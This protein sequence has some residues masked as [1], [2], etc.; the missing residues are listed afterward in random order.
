MPPSDLA[1]S[2]LNYGS[3]SA[4]CRAT[5]RSHCAAINLELHTMCSGPEFIQLRIVFLEASGGQV[6]HSTSKSINGLFTLA[7]AFLE[8][9]KFQMTCY[10]VNNPPLPVSWQTVRPFTNS[11]AV[12]WLLKAL[13]GLD[14]Y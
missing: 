9:L 8:L 12:G 3:A 5:V 13:F 7:K 1:D 11:S 2:K 10:C 6:I 4:V 14:S